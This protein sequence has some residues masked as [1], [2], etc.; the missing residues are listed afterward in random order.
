MVRGGPFL[1]GQRRQGLAGLV[2]VEQARAAV[3]VERGPVEHRQPTVR[4]G[5]VPVGIVPLQLG[6]ASRTA[7]DRWQARH[8]LIDRT[9]TDRRGSCRLRPRHERHST[10]YVPF[11]AYVATT[12]RRRTML[13]AFAPSRR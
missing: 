3:L 11:A 7:D 9:A 5:V 10:I 2:Q 13:A 6:T 1:L 12:A 8:A 4:V